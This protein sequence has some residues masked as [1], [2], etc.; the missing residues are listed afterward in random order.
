[1][2][3]ETIDAAAGAPRFAF[4]RDARSVARDYGIV[5]VFV[6]LFVVLSITTPNFLTSQNLLNVLNQNAF[7]GIAACGATLVIIAGGFDLSVGAMFAVAGAVAA[8]AALHVDPVVGLLMGALAGALLGALNGLLVTGIGLH[9][10]LATLASGL[11]FSGV[12]VAVTGGF[13]IDASRFDSFVWLG[14][15]EAIPGVP[16]PVVLFALVALLLGAVLSRTR[17]GRYVYAVGGNAEA[18]RLSGV[19]VA[20]VTASTFVV[21]GLTATLAGVVEVSKSGTGQAAPGGAGSLALDTIAAVVIGGTSIKGGQGAVWRT[22]LGVLLLALITN[23]FNI[24]NVGPQYQ[25]IISAAIIV[26]AVALNSL[27]ARR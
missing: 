23:A 4:G 6:A 22:V 24:L 7:I 27:A 10:F 25:D 17:F 5:G 1:M 15:G 14:R 11:A 13:L 19:R 26:A 12:A 8:W 20:L 9:S 3:T 16:N 18:A 2:S 21:C